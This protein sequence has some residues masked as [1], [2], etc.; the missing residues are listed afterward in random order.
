MVVVPGPIG[1]IRTAIEVLELPSGK[2][3]TADET[4]ATFGLDEVN[5]ARRPV[6]QGAE[7]ESASVILW[8]AVPV[9]VRLVGKKVSVAVTPTLTLELT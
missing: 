9:M 4:M 6:P 8:G 2:K 1:W 3:S 5:C 7:A